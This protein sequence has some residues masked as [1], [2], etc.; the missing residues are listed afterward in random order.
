MYRTIL[1]MQEWPTMWPCSLA[2]GIKKKRKKKSWIS[3]NE[4]TSQL[5]NTDK[6]SLGTRS[7]ITND[8]AEA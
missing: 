8:P 2:Q 6:K 5:A 3:I 1:F 7:E 4:I